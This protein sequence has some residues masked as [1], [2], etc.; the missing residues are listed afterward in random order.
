MKMR[1]DSLYEKLSA[2]QKDSLYCLILYLREISSEGLIADMV[3][4]HI[5]YPSI[6]PEYFSA[7]AIECLFGRQLPV[8]IVCDFDLAGNEPHEGVEWDDD[9]RLKALEIAQFAA[10]QVFLTR[11]ASVNQLLFENTAL[12]KGFVLREE[13]LILMPKIGKRIIGFLIEK[14]SATS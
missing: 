2:F 13:K 1:F 3:C 12:V 14:R 7:H 4:Q 11:N 8:I 10:I 9:T 5:L 6:S